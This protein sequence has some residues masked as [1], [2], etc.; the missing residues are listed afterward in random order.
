[1]APSGSRRTNRGVSPPSRPI[2]RT[3]AT[4]AGLSAVNAK[5]SKLPFSTSS[6]ERIRSAKP[7]FRRTRVRYAI[8]FAAASSQRDC[9]EPHCPGCTLG[10]NGSTMFP[11]CRTVRCRCGNS[12]A[13][14]SPTFPSTCPRLT[15]WPLETETLP[16]AKWQYCVSHPWGCLRKTPFPHFLSAIA[17]LP[18]TRIDMS[19][20]PSLTPVTLPS[21][22]ARTATPARIA[23]IEGK[24]KSVPSCPS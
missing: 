15:C 23:V 12:V 8:T 20:S 6:I 9:L 7:R 11:L 17:A 5:F 10:E 18:I 4:N 22:T 16:L 3:F 13:P 2:I 1:M 24:R 21:A 14:E 19:F